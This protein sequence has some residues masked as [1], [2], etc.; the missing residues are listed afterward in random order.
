MQLPASGDGYILKSGTSR[1][2]QYGTSTAVAEV[3]NLGRSWMAES[4]ANFFRNSAL[5]ITVAPDLE[6]SISIKGPQAFQSLRIGEMSKFGGGPLPPHKGPGHLSG[7]AADIGLFRNDGKN[8]GG[9]YNGP[10]YDR[11]TTQRFVNLLDS[12]DNV[13]SYYFNDS[14]VTGSK[15]QRVAGHDNHIHVNFKPCI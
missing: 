5:A 10:N 11:A 9:H 7:N 4:M 13:D 15:L 14:Q 2:N 3:E 1:K 12:D 8:L 6:I